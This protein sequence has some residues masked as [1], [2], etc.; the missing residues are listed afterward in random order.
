[1]AFSNVLAAIGHEP[2]QVSVDAVCHFTQDGGRFSVSRMDPDVH[3]RV[4]GLDQAAFEQ[5][6]ETGDRNCP[7]SDAL[8]GNVDIR[9]VA[10]LDT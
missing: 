9:L 5:L 10:T 4:P 7:V 3:G 8:R 1:M 2:E 6:A